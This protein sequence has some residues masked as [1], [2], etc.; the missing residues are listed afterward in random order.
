MLMIGNYDKLHAEVSKR[1]MEIDAAESD[2]EYIKAHQM[3]S[4]LLDY[5]RGHV[6]AAQTRLMRSHIAKGRFEGTTTPD[7]HTEHCCVIH[8][9]KYRDD[10]CTVETGQ[11]V[12]SFP[13]EDCSR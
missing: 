9:C 2:H 12:Q 10:N 7:V 8:G 13:C 5:I 3:L 1:L 4:G 11:S 6:N